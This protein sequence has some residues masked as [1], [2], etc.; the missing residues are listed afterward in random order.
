MLIFY[1]MMKQ[2]FSILIIF[3]LTSAKIGGDSLEKNSIISLLNFSKT[4]I[5]DGELTCLFYDQFPTP[6]NEKGENLRNIVAL[7]EQELRNARKERDDAYRQAILNN[8][9]HEK[10]YEPFRE[11]D[12]YFVFSEVSIVFQMQ[13][14]YT[15]TGYGID[16]RMSSIDRYEYHPSLG[17]IRHFNDGYEFLFLGS[18]T[19]FITV[20][21]TSQFDS[22]RSVAGI[23]MKQE[24]DTTEEVNNITELPPFHLI[25]EEHANVQSTEFSGEKGYII[26]HF[27]FKN[28]KEVLA[29]VYVRSSSLPEVFREDYYFQSDSPNANAEGYWL[30]VRTEYSDFQYVSDLNITVPKKRVRTEFRS[31]G[32]LQRQTVYTIKEMSFNLGLPEYFFEIQETDLDDD[33][34][35]RKEIIR[36]E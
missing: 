35:N 30:R 18:G 4:L 33:K 13:P 6:P 36:F 2:I 3:F 28:E 25:D 14:D 21:R 34:G 10:K 7:R 12:D 22:D 16:Y 23:E 11:S 1:N 8:L 29:K 32:W 17:H 26:T 5:Q 19:D 20:V 27:P 15:T 24:D 9:E 31:N